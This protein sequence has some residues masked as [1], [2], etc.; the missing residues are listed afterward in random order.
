MVSLPSSKV[1][2]ASLTFSKRT[3]QSSNLTILILLCLFHVG[4]TLVLF[5]RVKAQVTGSVQD[6]LWAIELKELSLEELMNIEVTSVS[7][8]PEKL[9]EVASAIQVITGDDIRRSGASNI[10]EALKLAANLAVAQRGS[11]SW[12]I[13]ARGFNTELANKLL[14]MIDGR[15]VYTPLF[16]GVFWDRQDYL[17]QDIDRI[18][19]ISGPG[20]TLWGANAVNGVINIITK[21]ARETRGTYLSAGGGSALQYF[22]RM[23]YGGMLDSNIHFRAY[24]KYS[25]RDN[26]FLGRG[27]TASDSWR[28]GQG[29]FRIDR[30]SSQ[31]SNFTLQ[32]DVYFGDESLTAGGAA[33]VSGGNILGR[34]S[35]TFS[36]DASMTLQLYF[37]RTHLSTAAPALIINSIQFAPAGTFKDDLHTYDID[38]QHRFG[39]SDYNHVVW[40]V[41]YR[42][43]HDVVGNAPTLAFFPLVLD[44]NLF[45]AF[46]QDE[47]MLGENLFFTLGTKV[48]HNYYTG[49]EVEPS[50]QLRWNFV[51]NQVLWA[52]VARAVRAPSRIDREISQPAPPY[53]VVLAGGENF[54]SETV[55]AYELGYRGQLGSKIAASISAFYNVYRNVR[56]TSTTPTV[57]LPFY[58]E[59][60]LEGETYGFEF[61]A[62]Y[63]PVDWLRLRGG[64]NLL[65][66]SIRIKSGQQDFNNAL[67]ETADPEHQFSLRS[68]IDLSDLE[69]DAQLRWV[70]VLHN[71]NGPTVGTVPSY[72]ELDVR[73]GWNATESLEFSLVG[74]NL[75]HDHHPE[76]G[77]PSPART[78]IRRGAYGKVS[79]IL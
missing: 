16:S 55:L 14:V 21:N 36:D 67:N 26:E 73:L 51:A 1:P 46:V 72:A 57:I 79:C 25:Q 49:V 48:E 41:G 59:N 45:S 52:A 66:T 24:G 68:S 63:Q 64:Y 11:H 40:G 8:H 23:R 19:V 17:L 12:G 4:V 65:K 56:S 61:S 69:L 74:R 29:G 13:S 78:E 39:L 54:I 60:N 76:Y 5:D 38:F 28:M 10:P 9:G 22:A 3:T 44:Q 30:E 43:T 18:E 77:F 20:G 7:R 15:T 37:D 71:N 58:F 6:T 33:K 31:K 75:L 32:G 50:A 35:K 42:L 2:I 53:L 47:I 34:W 27:S 70:D 62:N